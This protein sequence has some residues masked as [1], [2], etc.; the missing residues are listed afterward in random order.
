MELLCNV[1]PSEL[2]LKH[3]TREFSGHFSCS[4]SNIVGEGY[5]SETV[6]LNVMC[7]FF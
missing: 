7:K 6:E 3:V 5:Q 4:G 2:F 1:D